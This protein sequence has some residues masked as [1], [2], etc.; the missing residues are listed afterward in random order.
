[1]R[2]SI[3]AFMF[4]CCAIGSWAQQTVSLDSCIIE[5]RVSDVADGVNTPYQIS[6]LSD[7]LEV[8]YLEFYF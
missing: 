7:L 4:G 6:S 1:M 8:D 2:K 3:L 5:G